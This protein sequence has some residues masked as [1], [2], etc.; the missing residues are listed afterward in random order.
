MAQSSI[1][2]DQEL[3]VLCDL[4]TVEIIDWWPPGRPMTCEAGA[5]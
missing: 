2:N 3:S 5:G 4:I 1:I